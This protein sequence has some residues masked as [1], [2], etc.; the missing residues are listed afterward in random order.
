MLDYI[1]PRMCHKQ[2]N[3]D[4]REDTI[5]AERNKSGMIREDSAA[6]GLIRWARSGTVHEYFRCAVVAHRENDISLQAM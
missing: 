5:N 1:R 2:D 6:S 3:K 4:R